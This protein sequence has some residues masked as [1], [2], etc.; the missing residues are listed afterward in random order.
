MVVTAFLVT[1]K[2]NQVRFFEE[3][4]L[5]ANISP[6]VVFGILFLALNS[7]DINILGRELQWRTYN[8]K[9]ALPTTRR[10]KLVGK[11]E[12]AVGAL[13]L[14]H[15]T[16]VVHVGSLSSVASPSSSL[17]NIHPFCRPQIA[18]LIAKEAPTKISAKYS[19]FAD[20]FF[21]DL[22]SKLSE[23]TKINKHT[24]KLVDGQQ[25]PYRSIYSLVLVELET[26]KAY[27]KA[28]LANGFL[29]PSKS[30]TSAPILF[31]WKLDGFLRL[32]I[33]Y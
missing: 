13:D 27:I 7:T 5:V 2:A 24:I 12:F 6:K 23:H 16:Y 28:N 9:K 31:D 17:L 33:N 20:V 15:E 1:D 3:P 11:K 30:P 10:V 29:R 19:D 14:E 21:P 22:V 4:F 32:C 26:L 8:T 18:G 25:P